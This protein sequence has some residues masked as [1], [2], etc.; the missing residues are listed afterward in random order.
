MHARVVV[1]RVS[2]ATKLSEGAANPDAP[3]RPRRRR[4]RGNKPANGA[5]QAPKQGE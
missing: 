2:R 3:K 1:L 4:Y 5:P